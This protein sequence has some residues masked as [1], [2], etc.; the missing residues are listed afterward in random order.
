MRRSYYRRRENNNFYRLSIIVVSLIILLGCWYF[1]RSFFG[2]N[3]ERILNASELREK[4]FS[5]DVKEITAPQSGIK[6]YLLE[7]K[8]N[9][10]ISVGFMFKNAGRA[11]ENDEQNG[12]G[13]LVSALLLDGAGSLD[14]QMLKEELEQNAVSISFAAGPDDFTGSLLTTKEN[15]SNAFY[16]LRQILTAPR[17]EKED[18][19]RARKQHLNALKR[20]SEHPQNVLNLAF[21]EMLYDTHPYAR[22]PLGSEKAFR[23]IGE[24]ELRTFVKDRFAKDNLIIGIAG[25]ITQDEAQRMIDRVFGSLPDKN[26]I[27]FVRNAKTDF[28][29]RNRNIEYPAGQNIAAFAAAGLPRN[30]EN[31]YP[32]YVANYI[33][34]GSGLNSRLSVA[35]REE[36]GL[37]YSIYSYLSLTDKSPLIRG[38]FSS[39]PDNYDEV[40]RIL[41][42]EMQ[43]FADKGVSDKEVKD[44]KNYLVSS[45]NLRFASIGNL[46]DILMYMQRENLGID[47]LQKRNEYVKN[48]TKKEINAAAAKFFKPENFVFATIG[49]FKEQG[50]E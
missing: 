37:T 14:S 41:K 3:P 49:N 34:G 32:L 45:Y 22:N 6:A 20:Q 40:R 28:D 43:R 10:V 4:T 13:N 16:F 25:D 35:A 1:W 39:T 33:F 2:F 31:F 12:I 36:K 44:A 26:D 7:D 18:V 30:D 29:G 27:T 23:N 47:F 15:S 46:S 8:T 42:E 38:G 48:V 17:F 21:A 24:K 19:N 50:V 9:P 11:S 5:A